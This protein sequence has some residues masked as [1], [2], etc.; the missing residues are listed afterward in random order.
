[1][2][3]YVSNNQSIHGRKNIQSSQQIRAPSQHLRRRTPPPRRSPPR[4]P[5]LHPLPNRPLHRRAGEGCG[6]EIQKTSI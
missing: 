1:M 2:T 3:F 6:D 5:R 4:I